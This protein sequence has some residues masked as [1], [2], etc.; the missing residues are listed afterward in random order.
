MLTGSTENSR[1]AELRKYT[2]T[3]DFTKQYVSNGSWTNN[4]VD[5]N[6]STSGVSVVYYINGIKYVDETTDDTTITKFSFIPKNEANFISKELVKN[7][8]KDKIISNPKIID[9]VFITR[10]DLSAFDR[11]YRL[12]FIR[13]LFELTTYAGGK[14]FK[15][16]NNT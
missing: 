9:D 3:T 7:P 6:N 16:I 8:N 14:Y 1:L 13:N 11:N 10:N 5:Y 12:E 4:G 15:I 2:I